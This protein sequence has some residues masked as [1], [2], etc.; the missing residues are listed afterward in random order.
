MLFNEKR[1]F[2]S[3]A[4]KMLYHYHIVGVNHSEPVYTDYANTTKKQNNQISRTANY[5][6]LAFHF[7]NDG[8]RELGGGGRALV[9]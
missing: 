5:L 7:Q 8:G 6:P 1:K 2:S 3:L 9:Y 4:Y